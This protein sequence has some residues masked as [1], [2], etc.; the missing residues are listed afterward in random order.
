MFWALILTLCAAFTAGHA[1]NCTGCT[2]EDWASCNGTVSACG[3]RQK[4]VSAAS[5]LIQALY[6]EKRVTKKVARACVDAG[7]CNANLSFNFK[8]ASWKIRTTCDGIQAPTVSGEAEPNGLRCVGCI[9]VPSECTKAVECR[10]EERMCITVTEKVAGNIMVNKGCA[11][12]SACKQGVNISDLLGPVLTGSVSCCE[13]NLC[14]GAGTGWHSL[15]LQ[16]LL[17]PLVGFLLFA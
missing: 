12:R 7:F 4:C 1:L 13:G 17:L 16:L 11:T 2:A 8:Y 5:E 6:R 9:A 15:L 3:E 14:N 10:G